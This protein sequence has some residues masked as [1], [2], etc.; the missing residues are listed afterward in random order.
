VFMGMGEPLMNY[1]ATW[2]T[3]RLLTD[4]LGQGLSARR[5]TISTAGWVP[6]I[7]RSAREGLPVKLALSLHAPVDALRDR[8]VPLNRRYPLAQ[9]GDAC[10][11]YV[12]A[13]GRRLSLEYALMDGLNDDPALAEPLARLFHGMPIHVNL[14]PLSPASQM[15]PSPPRR[16]LAFTRALERLGISHTFRS[17]RGAD[18]E[19]ACGQLR[20]R[21]R[22]RGRP[23]P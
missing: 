8:L 20:R 14:I 16:A 5:I 19:A 15:R 10:R 11:E 6:G 12:R 23:R 17:S 21:T 9:V 1:E 2:R 4:P 18:I 22:P 7:R 13:T 3:I